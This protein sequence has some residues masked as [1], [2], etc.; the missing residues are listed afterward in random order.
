MNIPFSPPHIDDAIIDE[1]VAAL[2]SG[3]ITTGPRT[4]LFEKKLAEYCGIQ[5][6]V[7]VNSASAGL[8]LV[9]RWFGIGPGD[10]VIV[11]AYTYTASAEV[12]IHCGAKPVMV[13]VDDDLL[14]DTDKVRQAITPRTKVILPVDIVGLPCDYEQLFDIVNDTAVKSQYH[15]NTD[16]QRAL[17]RILILADAAH[18]LG[19][20]Y[21]G[22]KTGAVADITVFSFHAVKNLTTAEGGAICL[23][24][25]APF[26]TE[27]VYKELSVNT[28]HGQ[29]KDALAKTKAGGWR[30]DV[31]SV[32]YKCNMTD[33]AAAMGLVELA[34][35]DQLIL[36]R[37]KQIF[38]AY[39]QAFGNDKRFKVP[40]YET[41]DK[42][43]SYHV[44]TLRV[45]G[46]TEEQRDEILLKMAQ[47]GVAAN[48]H[49][50]PLPLLT[51][52]KSL[53]YNIEDYPNAYRQYACEISLPVYFNLTDEQ[54]A[55][56]IRV[57][58]AAV[59]EVCGL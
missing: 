23:N 2:R 11:P 9:L 16:P 1:V 21:R 20:R 15:P 28:L 57:T 37:R 40:T 31:T 33:V 43:S 54:V 42:R 29:S 3:W 35:Y 58:K 53:G 47:Q 5:Q 55:E 34:R 17:G 46:A 4:K 45:N 7:C 22:K 10:E 25:P 36:P 59:A 6:V 8:E 32:G 50:I 13:D 56:V 24:L 51:A 41:P 48:V 52:Y 27:S 30:Y 18:S 49:F 38:D 26:D 14:M 19:A 39:S 12:V 44:F